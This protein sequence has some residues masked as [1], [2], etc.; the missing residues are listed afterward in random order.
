[1]KTNGS[2]TLLIAGALA[3]TPIFAADVLHQ[4]AAFRDVTAAFQY[5]DTSVC[6]GGIVT[7]VLVIGG[8]GWFSANGKA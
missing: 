2:I 6:S 7:N 5:V 8:L 1:M 3:A 4:R